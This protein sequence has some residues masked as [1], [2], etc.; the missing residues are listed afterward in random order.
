MG[1]YER[2]QIE[3]AEKIIV[4]II[5][6]QKVSDLD[7]QNRWFKHAIA[8]AER[9]KKDF[10]N[11]K[12][13]QH[14]GNRYDNTGDILLITSDKREIFIEVKM[15][16]TRL[17]VG[18]KANVSQ[19]ALTENY[20]FV[21]KVKSWSKFRKEK[22][23]NEWVDSYLDLFTRYPK[24]I[25]N[26]SNSIIRREEKARY[27][28]GLKQK[29]SRKAKEILDKIHERDKKEKIEYLVYLS[30]QPQREE[31]IK[32]FF[33]LITL[34]IH[35]KEE[36]QALI[37]KDNFFQE[38]QDLLVYY[39]N[40]YNDKIIVRQE[41]AGEK[42]KKV[43][44]EFSGFKIIFPSGTTHCKLVGIKGKKN[45]PLLQIVLHWKNIAQG[46]K[47]PCLNIFDLTPK[48]INPY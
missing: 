11:I 18:T 23:H 14:L 48:F 46:I 44:E 37:K 31:M 38:I 39:G 36:L 40:S 10:P 20:L 32:R 43:L 22:K 13:A 27:L 4:K 26:I 21:G 8:I 45:I 7:K 5:N 47:T 17:G 24:K 12:K 1:K 9:I 16:D 28:R 3:E 30:K 41:N 35:K 33:I 6:S 25:L 15:S 29:G 42:I 2:E 19:D 34:G